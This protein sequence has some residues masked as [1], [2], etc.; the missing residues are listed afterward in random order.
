M[1]DIDIDGTL[2]L[3]S[4]RRLNDEAREY[5]T[6]GKVVLSH[7]VAA[8]PEED[9]AEI[10]ERVRNFE[11]FAPESDPYDEHDF[12]AFEHEGVRVVWKIDYFDQDERFGSPDPA[13]P[14]L[15]KR[16][17]TIMLAAEH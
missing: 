15:T 2:A 3:A 14:S 5:L 9:Q 1:Y 16:V 10:L 6:D 7:D 4:V 11:E 8:M 13:D 17:L 12:G